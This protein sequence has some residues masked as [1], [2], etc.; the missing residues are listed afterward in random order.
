MSHMSKILTITINVKPFYDD[1]TKN[2]NAK[3][4]IHTR[5][6]MLEGMRRVLLCM[7]EAVGSDLCLLDV[8][9]VMRCTRFC[10]RWALFA[11]DAGGRGGAGGDALYATLYAGAVKDELC[12]SAV[13]FCVLLI[14]RTCVMY[15]GG[16]RLEAVLYA[17]EVLEGE[18]CL[19]EVLEVMRCMLEAVEKVL[20]AGGVGGAGG[21]AP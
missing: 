7:L 10:G 9:N 6:E 15:A 4:D 14:H 21:D 8:L 5:V 16:W 1:T 19:L 18:R 2:K 3:A 11:G 12:L 20:F 17:L 13:I